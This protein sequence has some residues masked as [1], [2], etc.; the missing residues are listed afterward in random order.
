M[1]LDAAFWKI[2]FP[3][4]LPLSLDLSH[5]LVEFLSFVLREPSPKA[6]ILDSLQTE[7]LAGFRHASPG[8]IIFDVINDKRMEFHKSD[9]SID[10]Q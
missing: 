10:Y 2:L 7:V 9:S 4:D 3:T 5:S 8:S 1:L 6:A